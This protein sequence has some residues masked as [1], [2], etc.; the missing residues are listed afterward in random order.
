MRFVIEPATPEDLPPMARLLGQLFEQEADF[1]PDTAAQLRGLQQIHA[2]P[3]RGQLWVARAESSPSGGAVL[4]MVSLL[5]TTSTALGS[6][7]A[8][9]EDLVVD[10]SVRGRGIGSALL[11]TALAQAKACGV[12]RI[13]LLTDASNT[14]AQNL[15]RKKGFEASQMIPLRRML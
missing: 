8:W 1:H 7:A 10:A 5:W 11:D 4:G 2:N 6:T 15:Y 3:E 13:T 14:L 12:A 9:L